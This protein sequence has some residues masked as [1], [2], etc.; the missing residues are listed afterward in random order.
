M[1]PAKETVKTATKG[2]ATTLFI[3]ILLYAT[4]P[5]AA[6]ADGP[7][8]ERIDY[9]GWYL[10]IWNSSTQNAAR[11]IAYPLNTSS[12]NQIWYA[13]VVEGNAVIAMQNSNSWKFLGH[14]DRWFGGDSR[15]C[16]IPDQYDWVS[17]AYQLWE[18]RD[19]WSDHNQKGYYFYVNKAGCQGNRYHSNLGQQLLTSQ[20]YSIWLSLYE[21]AICS[22][23]R[24]GPQSQC[25]WTSY[26]P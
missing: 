4:L 21:Q 8:R 10:E 19:A 3:S 17:T 5:T 13:T 22:D 15:L 14:Q 20:G 1:N 6:R 23:Q 24:Y 2:L 11:A 26:Y 18:V 12:A 7:A 16:G 9:T 25:Y